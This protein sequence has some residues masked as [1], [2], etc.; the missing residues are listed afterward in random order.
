VDVDKNTD[1]SLESDPRW[2][3][4]S[5]DG[6][7]KAT[8]VEPAELTV[9]ARNAYGN[10]LNRGGDDFAVRVKDTN[11]KD[12]DT[13]LTDNGD[14]TYSA[15]YQPKEVGTHELGVTLDGINLRGTP[16]D[17]DV[18]QGADPSKTVAFG[19]GLDTAYVGVPA[20]FV[21]QAKDKFWNNVKGGGDKVDAHLN[22]PDGKAVPIKVT[23]NKNG[24]YNCEFT[25]QVAGPHK[26]NVTLEGT[27]ISEFPRVVQVKQS[28]DPSKTTLEGAGITNATTTEPAVFTIRSKDNTGTP[29]KVGGDDYYVKITP[30]QGGRPVLAS[31]RD[32]EDG[33]YTVTYQPTIPGK[34]LVDVSLNGQAVGGGT[35]EVAVEQIADPS[36]SVA[37]GPGFDEASTGNPAVF[38]VQAK[39]KNSN[40]LSKGGDKVDASLRGPSGDAPID[41]KDNGNGTYTITATPK[42]QGL[43]TLDIKLNGKPISNSSTAIPVKQDVSASQSTVSGPGLEHAK[44]GEPAEFTIQARDSSGAPVV[45]GGDKFTVKVGNPEGMP[46]ETKV[47]DNKD[48]TYTVTY[49][50]YAPGNHKVEVALLS[51]SVGKSPY[52]VPVTAG[53]AG[54]MGHYEMEV[55]RELN[56]ARMN[57]RL[58]ADYIKDLLPSYDNNT[59]ALN[60]PNSDYVRSTKEGKKGALEAI[61]FLETST[62]INPLKISEPFSNSARDLVADVGPKGLIGNTMSDGT[63]PATRLNRYG[64]WKNKVGEV[65]SYG[66]YSPRD[67]VIGWIVDDGVGQ[68]PNRRAIFDAEFT[69]V[70][71]SSG[72]H[73][74]HMT[75]CCACLAANY[76]EGDEEQRAKREVK[77]NYEKVTESF[78]KYE[79]ADKKGY[80][81]P[82]GNL[83]AKPTQLKL[84]KEGRQLHVTKTIPNDDGD[85]L[86]SDYRWDIPYDFEPISVT[87]K[88]H[89]LTD[90]LFLYLSKPIGTLDPNQE[91]QI[92]SFTIG[93]NPKRPNNKMDMKNTQNN[94]SVLFQCFSSTCREDITVFLKGKALII[95]AKRYEVGQDEEGEF[96]NVTTSKKTVNLPFPVTLAAFSL[97]KGEEEFTIKILKPTSSVAPDARIEIPIQVGHFDD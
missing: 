25:P 23:D 21:V 46:V 42:V 84:H 11:G 69:V 76:V 54:V 56:K 13:S 79:T 58:Y 53:Q 50:P 16:I 29:L 39:D 17:V 64:R 70:G 90:E 33:T 18:T 65:L 28:T 80:M 66:A 94:D 40:N 49:T 2:S 52:S 55:W 10:P 3:T 19:P 44:T 27:S 51:K 6:T 30:P 67:V 83:K 73:A 89:P 47:K 20:A 38:I 7:E 57:P 4:V 24:T 31:V 36:R 71:V 26:L 59:G 15:N 92:T 77:V 81:I 45:R 37:Y 60:V 1:R 86:T 72:P 8:I 48:G 82:A 88:I 85:P 97:V 61:R 41:I 74:K 63:D 34:H 78:D 9:Q 5:G 75:M 96:T 62:S 91:V 12:V 35:K 14:G 32:N 43:H 22:A 68:R 95:A 87:A 93:P